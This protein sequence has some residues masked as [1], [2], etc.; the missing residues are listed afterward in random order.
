MIAN[1]K[2]R[3]ERKKVAAC[4]NI[5]SQHLPEETEEY[6]RVYPKVSGLAA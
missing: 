6:R 1:D 5:I 3:R 4:L 2:E